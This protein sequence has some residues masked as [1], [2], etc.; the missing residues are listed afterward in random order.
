MTLFYKQVFDMA[1]DADH[2][3]D[4]IDHMLASV[5]SGRQQNMVP[6]MG[7]S[8]CDECEEKIPDARRKLGFRLCIECAE[9]NERRDSL[10]AK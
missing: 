5:L 7:A 6:R 10:F 9:E 3:S 8:I 1:D 4:Y 2:A